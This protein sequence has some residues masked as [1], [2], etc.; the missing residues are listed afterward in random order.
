MK[1]SKYIPKG[2][3]VA[4]MR[5][6]SST[7]E[8]DRQKFAISQSF[9]IDKIFEEKASGKIN[10]DRPILTECINYLREGDRLIISS[11]DRLG[12]SLADLTSIVEQILN[13]G[14]EIHFIKEKLT[15]SKNSK[16]PIDNL[17]LGILA[18]IAEFERELIKERQ[19]EGIAAAKEKGK[20]FGRRKVIDQK[21]AEQIALLMKKGCTKNFIAKEVGIGVASL[22]VFLRENKHLKNN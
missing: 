17:L 18:S 11:L 20:K 19:K 2:Q 5:V 6:S 10:A 15:F 3:Q 21:K 16:N 13:K 22:Y 4:Y 14:V 8:T 12:R 9:H 7:Q 1:E